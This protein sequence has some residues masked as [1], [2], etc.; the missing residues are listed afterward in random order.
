MKI[1]ILGSGDV[2]QAL[3]RGFASRGYSVRIGSRKPEDE[4]LAGWLEEVGE[5]GSTGTLADT[6]A[7][8][9]MIVMAVKGNAVEDALRIAGTKNFAN[10]VVIDV[11]N[12]LYFSKGNPPSIFTWGSESLA[13]KIQQTV[14]KAKVVKCWNI[15]PNSMMVDPQIAGT[16]PTMMICGNDDDA[17][18]TVTGILQEFGWDDIV[19]IGNVEGARYLEALVA[20][21][22]RVGIAR[23][24]Y[25]H[26]FKDLVE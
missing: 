21:W 26:A 22:A 24:T 13:E 19:D 17:K 23:G 16:K 11:T 1:G 14:I 2:G 4:K 9:E 20:L 5:R 10:K 8:G 18:A 25:N 15:V 3:G 7:Y 12:P 6:A